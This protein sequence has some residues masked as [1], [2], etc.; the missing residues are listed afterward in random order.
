M[1][2]SFLDKYRITNG[3]Y[4]IWLDKKENILFRHNDGYLAMDEE[5]TEKCQSSR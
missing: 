4:C 5:T 1:E 2:Y 3:T